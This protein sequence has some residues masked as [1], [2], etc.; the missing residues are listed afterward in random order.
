M[1]FVKTLRKYYDCNNG[2]G[3]S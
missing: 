2:W 3:P 1:D